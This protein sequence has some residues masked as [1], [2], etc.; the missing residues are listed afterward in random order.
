M[1]DL[2]RIAHLPEPATRPD[3]EVLI[4]INQ[5]M[6]V[7][8]IVPGIAH[9]LNNS[10]QV[11]GGLIEMLS[12]RSDL[13]AD[14]VTRLQRIGAHADRA[15]G[16][17]R[18][19]QAFARHEPAEAAQTDVRGITERALALRRYQLARARVDVAVE[20]GGD[21]I[22]ARIGPRQ[23]QLVILNLL[24]NAEQ[25][26]AGRNDGVVRVSVGRDA[27]RARVAVTD[28]GPGV[29]AD[30]RE[31]IFEAFFTTRGREAAAGIGL[32]AAR[33]LARRHGGDLWVESAGDGGARFVVELP[34]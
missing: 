28:N 27:G 14:V 15:A 17:V 7:G 12:A 31:Q 33:G 8:Q 6:T 16:R 34:A 9:E 13:P 22:A 24:I 32:A 1:P 11:I 25:A 21:G 4:I 26:L 3:L 2:G 20:P 5:L 29:P 30:L 23:L 10:F 19:L 18:D